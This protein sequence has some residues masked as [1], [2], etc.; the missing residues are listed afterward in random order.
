MPGNICHS[1]HNFHSCVGTIKQSLKDFIVRGLLIFAYLCL[2][3]EPW[4]ND[5]EYLP[6]AHLCYQYD[7][8]SIKNQ[9]KSIQFVM[10]EIDYFLLGNLDRSGR[11]KQ[12]DE[13][14]NF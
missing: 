12:Q 7:S 9:F 2:S 1:H 4:I 6:T 11:P 8:D 3:I 5:Q 10:S 14:I 13:S